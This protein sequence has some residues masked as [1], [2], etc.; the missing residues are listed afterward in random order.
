MRR[1]FFY[2]VIIILLLHGIA[3]A[4]FYKWEDESGTIHITDY[5][6]QASSARNIQVH[7][8]ESEANK[9]SAINRSEQKAS[10]P[11][12]A[13]VTK[14]QHVHPYNCIK[15]CLD[16]GRNARKACKG[17]ADEYH[18][19]MKKTHEQLNNCRQNC[20]EEEKAARS[21]IIAGGNTE[22]FRSGRPSIGKD[23]PSLQA[24]RFNLIDQ[25]DP[26]E[27][28]GYP[29]PKS[30]FSYKMHGDRSLDVDRLSILKTKLIAQFGTKLEGKTI[31]LT[32]FCVTEATVR[33]AFVKDASGKQI[34]YT[35]P[36]LP[37]L[38][39]EI[40]LAIGDHYYS[41]SGTL[42]LK[43][44]SRSTKSAL[45][46]ATAMAVDDLLRDMMRGESFWNS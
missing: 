33:P 7:Q 23:V 38:M 10:T 18:S 3:F 43:Q 8:N 36:Y 46:T 21:G 14:E 20:H 19:C 28:G 31:I 16:A 13:A 17:S 1:I 45:S 9:R 44:G 35:G 4:E 11:S 15:I 32:K 42:P 41:G 27:R 34:P 2:S 40:T 25:R 29:Y 5:P 26:A 39:S 30:W 22:P 6:P 24:D 12:G 37:T